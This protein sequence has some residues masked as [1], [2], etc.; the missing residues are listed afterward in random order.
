MSWDKSLTDTEPT[1]DVHSKMKNALAL[2]PPLQEYRPVYSATVPLPKFFIGPVPVVTDL[3]VD[4]LAGCDFSIEGQVAIELG[5]GISSTVEIGI[6]YDHGNW[7]PIASTSF[8][9]HTIGP[10]LTVGGTVGLE[11]SLKPRFELRFYGLAGPYIY[12]QPYVASAAARRRARAARRTAGA[13]ARRARSSPPRTTG[14]CKSARTAPT[15][16]AA[17]SARRRATA[18]TAARCR[19]RRPTR[20]RS[21]RTGP[22]TTA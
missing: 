3:Y 4:V 1:Q 9:K 21:R 16:C 22:A 17:V 11:C 18:R 14:R 5:V 13:A 20:A 19:R 7:N 8:D 6:P 12:A 10:N 2:K 15:I